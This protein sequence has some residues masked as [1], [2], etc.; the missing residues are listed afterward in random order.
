VPPRVVIRQYNIDNCLTYTKPSIL[1]R[2]R[3]RLAGI[4]YQFE[5]GRSGEMPDGMAPEAISSRTSLM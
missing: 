2:E 1:E 3:I 4:Y 5:H